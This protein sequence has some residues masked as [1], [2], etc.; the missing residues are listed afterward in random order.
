MKRRLWMGAVAA[1]VLIL[2]VRFPAQWAAGA[3]PRDAHCEQLDGTLWSGSCSG[4]SAQG[5]RLGDLTWSLHPLR[6][7][8]GRLALDLSLTQPATTS[9][10]SAH[11]EWSL[12]GTLSARDVHAALVL[13]HTLLRQLP[14]SLHARLDAQLAALRW[15]GKRVIELQ[16]QMEVRGL[17]ADQNTPLG[18]YRVSFSGGP[19]DP[20][21]ALKD[22]GGPLAVEG[23]L[24]LTP[25]PGY[26]VAGLVA[27]R[28][29]APADLAQQIRYLGSPDAQG[30][31][32][33]SFAGTF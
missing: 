7:L 25:E 20:V 17:T 3:L 18:D 24:R 22:I 21:G 26:V 1:F 19:G 28:P 30:R 14:P 23:T 6:L 33:F 13:D 31:R 15:D 10:A 8:S 27:A 12:A 9:G 4:L 16:G 32:P 29:S 11:V 5:S 2:L